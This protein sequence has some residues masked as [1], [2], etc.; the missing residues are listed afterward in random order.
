MSSLLELSHP[1][2]VAL[3]RPS[4]PV[5]SLVLV[6]RALRLSR[7][8]VEALIT[9]A[10]LPVILMVMFVYLFGGALQTGTAYVD[11]VVPGVIVVCAGF[12]AGTTAVSVATDLSGPII[13]RLRTLDVRGA[14]LVQGQVL[15]SVLRNLFS[16]VLVVGVALAIGF[17]TSVGVGRWLAALGVLTAFVV[18]VSWLAAAIGILARNA[19]AA[20]GLTFMIAFLPYPSSAFVPI[21]TMPSWL[22]GFATHQ[23]VTPVV[24]AMRSLLLGRPV[25]DA[26]WQALVWSAVI[27][28]VAALAASV[29]FRRRTA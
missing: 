7:R 22:R 13:D 24:D 16:T 14:A 15:A 2:R 10:A 11:Y 20:S 26:A 28:V 9:A 17:R 19:E 3:R 23:P 4:V 1:P 29:L 27:T 12:G 25:G 8:N 21:H 18:A 6:G 5:E